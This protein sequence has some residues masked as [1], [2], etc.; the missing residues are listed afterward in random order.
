M[1]KKGV[2]LIE[3][4]IVMSI[5][6]ILAGLLVPSFRGYQNEAWVIKAEGDISTL[7]LA[8]ESYYRKNQN[9]Y[10]D[11]LDDLL[12]EKPRLIPRMPVDPF[13]TDTTR[14]GFEVA[15]KKPGNE[16]FYIIYSQGPNRAKN[17]EWNSLKGT[18]SLNPEGDDILFTNAIIE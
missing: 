12:S 15:T 6:V 18:V 11:T 16:A 14:Y 7:Q 10:P 8:V 9:T 3:L 1:K 5:L 13:K 17:W 4:L 2:T